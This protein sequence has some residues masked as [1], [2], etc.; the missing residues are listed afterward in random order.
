MA[1][2]ELPSG[3]VHYRVVGPESSAAPPVVF[4]GPLLTDGALWSRVADDLAERG[5]RSY[6]PDWP[7]GAH[8][9]AMKPDADLSPRGVARLV[10]E[11]LD[12]LNLDAVTL[13]GN[14]TGGALCQFAIDTDPRRVGR[15]VLT[16]C[17]GV[18]VFPPAVFKPLFAL[19]RSERRA[20][21]LA[22]QMRVRA[23][24]QS[25]LGFGLL[26]HDLP[27]ELTR[28]WIEPALRDDGVVRDLTRFLR[29]VDPKELL[30]VASRLHRFQGPVTLVWGTGDRAFT[31]KLG[32]RL[33]E[34]F[35][36]ARFVPVPR[37]RTFVPLDAPKQL[38]DEIAAIGA[39]H[40]S[41][42]VSERSRRSGDR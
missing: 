17:D 6:A 12:A 40:E 41:A 11:F 28:A 37:S 35:R 1:A 16:N 32:R 9:V 15:V 18:D 8:R 29:A 3:T 26:A 33:Q 20:R 25:W 38:A 19:L 39:A 21:F 27:A 31:T 23:L 14:D 13:V 34:F 24:R 10:L 4:V 2:I 7:L 42:S 22:G 36:D 5:I 30:D